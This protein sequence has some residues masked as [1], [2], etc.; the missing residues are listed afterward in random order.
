MEEN[1]SGRDTFLAG[2]EDVYMEE[3]RFVRV[4]RI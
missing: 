2:D 3:N 1:T 4:E